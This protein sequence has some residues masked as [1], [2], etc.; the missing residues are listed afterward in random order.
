MSQKIPWKLESIKD[1]LREFSR[2]FIEIPPVK[3]QRISLIISPEM[4]AWIFQGVPFGTD[5]PSE[6]L[7]GS[8]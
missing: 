1:S 5:F 8:R 7:T 6:I 3:H 4:P 2:N